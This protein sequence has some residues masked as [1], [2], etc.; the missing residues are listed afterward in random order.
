MM[1]LFVFYVLIFGLFGVVATQYMSQYREAYGLWIREIV[2]ND[3]TEYNK[4]EKRHLCSRVESLSREICEL[5]NIIFMVI[6]MLCFTFL[7]IIYTITENL[8]LIT[9]KK[10]INILYAS[11][12]LSIM[13]LV[14]FPII[15]YLL[16]LNILYKYNTSTIDEKL[17]DL[18][19]KI[20]CH[21]CKHKDY[22]NKT[23]P[24]QLYEILAERIEKGDIKSPSDYE[25]KII[26]QLFPNKGGV[27]IKP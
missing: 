24:R 6:V 4:N 21:G 7:I 15:L 20:N 26:K 14:A 13:I 19:Y 22:F 8:P 10:E 9:D 16:K 2:Y 3:H 11:L 23:E 27:N 1:T 12:L 5:A 18:W 25:I 17:F